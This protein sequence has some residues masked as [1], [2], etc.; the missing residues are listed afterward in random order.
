MVRSLDAMDVACDVALG[1]D[2]DALIWKW[3]ALVRRGARKG[4]KGRQAPM[5]SPP[6]RELCHLVLKT[7]RACSVE[8][9]PPDQIPGPNG[10][11]GV[12]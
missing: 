10:K 2:S 4:L 1:I 11:N 3:C 12:I 8:Q 7:P 9:A 5:T 6:Q